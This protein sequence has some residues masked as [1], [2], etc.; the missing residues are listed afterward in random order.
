[1][2]PERELAERLGVSRPVIREALQVL[3]VRG[4]A[5]IKPGCG[6]FVCEPSAQGT[7]AQLELYF[8]LK[9][10]PNALRDFFEIRR[11]LEVESA[12]L[13]AERA[14]TDDIAVLLDSVGEMAEHLDSLTEFIQADLSFHMSLARAAH[15][16][17][18]QLLLGSISGLWSQAISLSANAPGALVAG[19]THHRE[20][21]RCITCGDAPGAREA[22]TSHMCTAQELTSHEQIVESS[23]KSLVDSGG[24]Q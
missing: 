14:T 1:L 4:L 17:Y 5:Q 12:G 24:A 6:T 20:I 2:P 21:L 9:H 16:D 13:A 8:Q 18:I 10:C 15:N 19:L 7:A 23:S 22:M 3:S 11:L